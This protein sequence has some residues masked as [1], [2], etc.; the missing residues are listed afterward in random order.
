[1]L[2]RGVEDHEYYYKL[3]GRALGPVSW[4]AIEEM[5]EDT[6]EADELMIARVGDDQWRTVQDVIDGKS[7]D[8]EEDEGD[9]EEEVAAAPAAAETPPPE[10]LRPVHGFSAWLGQAWEIF[11]E[12]PADYIGASV[13]VVVL[14]SL[15]FVVCLPPVHAGFYTMALRRFRGEGPHPYSVME[16]FG[17]FGRVV[18]LYLLILLVAI[19]FGVV[20]TSGAALAIVAL[21]DDAGPHIVLPVTTAL[22]WL[23]VS[24]ALAL[25]SAVAFFA[26]PLIIDRG[27]G[28]IE[29]LGQSW[30]VT[31]Q[32]FASYFAMTTALL[33]VS[34]LGLFLCWI[35]LLFTMPLLPLAQVCVY[36]YRF[37]NL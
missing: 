30:A 28:P 10:P 12:R 1:M 33:L 18:G 21:P 4:A 17:H 31:Q 25:P 22:V 34:G 2:P 27:L 13:A 14:G 9:E 29:A 5:L 3:G 11:T 24:L 8:E 20:F 16:G 32:S 36:E 37:R 23:A 35:G 19:P 15:S 6:F 26:V 7:A